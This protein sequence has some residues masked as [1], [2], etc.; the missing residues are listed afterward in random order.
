M[1]QVGALQ[2]VC[3]SLNGIYICTLCKKIHSWSEMPRK[4]VH[5]LQDLSVLL[6]DFRLEAESILL[7]RPGAA[8]LAGSADR[9]LAH[10]LNIVLGRQFGRKRVSRLSGGL[11]VRAGQVTLHGVDVATPWT[12]LSQSAQAG[13]STL[14]LE[15]PVD[16]KV[17]YCSFPSILQSQ[18]SIFQAIFSTAL[19]CLGIACVHLKK[20]KLSEPQGLPYDSVP[21]AVVSTIAH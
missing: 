1:L 11:V 7:S 12:R 2:L 6:Q 4:W 20:Q 10:K 18:Q 21:I 17:H 3:V 8:F 13:D 19:V 16:W 5:V 14:S 15:K 9:P